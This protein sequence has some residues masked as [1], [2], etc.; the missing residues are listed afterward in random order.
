MAVF[1]INYFD[2][3]YNLL[4]GLPTYQNNLLVRHH[5]LRYIGTNK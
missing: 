1:Y 4:S 3:Y 2:I 5:N